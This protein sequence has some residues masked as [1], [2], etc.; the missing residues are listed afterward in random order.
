MTYL[1]VAIFVHDI[2]Q[3]KQQI[4]QASEAGADLVEL[5]ID[6]FTDPPLVAQLLNESILPAIITCRASWEGGDCQLPDDQR[7]E[8]LASPATAAARYVDVELEA[9]RRTGARFPDRQ[10]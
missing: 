8:L 10:L 3:A 7:A 1:C 2:A 5:R 4:A 6:H 9:L